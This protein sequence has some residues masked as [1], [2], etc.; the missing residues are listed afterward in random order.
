MM[1]LLLRWTSIIPSRANDP[2]KDI[3]TFPNVSIK[4]KWKN[5]LCFFFFFYFFL[6]SF[7]CVCLSIAQRQAAHPPVNRCDGKL[8]FRLVNEISVGSDGQ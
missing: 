3:P 8:S 2:S 7:L 4:I 1:M 5:L 6:F